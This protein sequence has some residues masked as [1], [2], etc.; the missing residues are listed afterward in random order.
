MGSA[1]SAGFQAMQVGRF[2]V[3][4]L[5]DGLQTMPFEQTL[6]RTTPQHVRERMAQSFLQTTVPLSTNAYL[7]EGEGRRIL[8][9]TGTGGFIDDQVGL[10]TGSLAAAGYSPADVTDIVLTHFHFD[11]A[12]GLVKDGAVVFPNATL[13]VARRE[14]EHWFS[15]VRQ[16]AA[17]ANQQPTFEAV[18][19]MLGAYRAAGRMQMRE[20]GYQV[21]P[22]V[23]MLVRPGHTPGS[24]VA[25][26]QSDG[27]TMVF[28]GD[29]LHSEQVQFAEPGV[30]FTYD[31]NKDAAVA[32]RSAT[33][34]QAA[35]EKW[36]LALAHVSFPGIGRVRRDGQGYRW[37]AVPYGTD[38]DNKR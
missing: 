18:P 15:A 32:S 28:M 13:H 3:V 27:Q 35:K 22:G 12:G 29:L 2:K 37:V 21:I 19:K 25:K 30:A 23:T 1:R 6:V 24:A 4:A 38:A 9:D 8:V 11:H 7:I 26:L 5:S 16:K 17:A 31:E 14:A 33:L 10:L 34:A 36:L 20:D